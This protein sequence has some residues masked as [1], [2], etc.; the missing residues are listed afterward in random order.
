MSSPAPLYPPTPPN[1]P[2]D[3]VK[4]GL[5]YRLQL[6]VF[7]LT[8]FLFLLVYLALLAGAV[9]LLYWAVTFPV[10]GAENSTGA[11]WYPVLNAL[12]RIGVFAASVMLIAFL[13][14][15]LW[16]RPGDG[17]A[18]YLEVTAQQ[19]PELFQFL[20]MLCQEIGSPFPH[21]VC[22]SPEVNASVTWDSSVLS[23]FAPSRKDLVIGLGLV[24]VL[25]LVEFKAVLAHEFGHFSQ[26]SLTL[27]GYAYLAYR[28]LHDMVYARDRWDV[29]LYSWRETPVISS[30]GIPL[31][32]TIRL[33][34]SLLG[35]LFRVLTLVDVT[36]RRQMELN[37]DLVAVSATGSDALVTGFV[38]SDFA[39]A[40][41]YR[42]AQDL[43]LAAE[44]QLFTRD[45]FAHQRRAADAL[46]ALNKDQN[47][48]LPP[49]PPSD[50]EQ[51]VSL[52]QRGATSQSSMWADHPSYFDREQ[53]AKRR[54]FRSPRDDR[55]AW[56]LF[57]DAESLREEVTKRFY[58]TGLRLEPDETL[59][60]AERVQAFIDEEYA[61]FQFDPRYHGLYDNRYLEVADIDSLIQ[62]A[63]GQPLWSPEQ[64]A[65]AQQALVSDGLLSSAEDY[66][67]RRGEVESLERL[68]GKAAKAEGT[69]FEFR[70]R[71][72][73]STEAARCLEVVRE[74]L[75]EDYRRLAGFDCEV[76]VLHAQL[77]RQ[78]GKEEELYQHYRFHCEVQR[79]HRAL[80]QEKSQLDA[81]LGFLATH[82]AV[83]VQ[84]LGQVYHALC[85][86]RGGLEA[87]LTSAAA[88]PVPALKHLTAGK[89]LH[90][91]LTTEPVISELESVEMA[92]D[93]T[94]IGT[95]RRQLETVFDRLNRIQF[96][97]LGGILALQ[98]HLA[99]EWGRRAVGPATVATEKQELAG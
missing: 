25:S 93:S 72:L 32:W 43:A 62:E 55:P 98:E 7:L 14:K 12:V 34:R 79:L 15:G 16:K 39:A 66:R 31:E 2:A 77:A 40:C 45:L 89:P 68:Q 13:L 26:R 3:L 70:G 35:N 82:K 69:E 27:T 48:G 6:M 56:L 78:E 49:E 83:H 44:Q 63:D 92:L 75:D 37:A 50:P 42:A 10:G 9:F 51:P 94:W 59:A 4:P 85:A 64:V 65:S 24:D 19:Q 33:L 61:V 20:R 96:K 73:A 60:D 87:V 90:G 57:R 99:E 38:R 53:N 41:Q 28:I 58:R 22:L 95:L 47:L 8:L 17:N 84:E 91:Y 52:F 21:R 67:R 54:Y 23:L 5:R 97:S 76:F 88:L 18:A 46:R 30:L 80:W 71:Q 86:V 1:I 11:W 29:W 81:V 36:F 74:E